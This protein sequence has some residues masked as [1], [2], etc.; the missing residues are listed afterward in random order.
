ML[1]EH[2]Q[3]SAVSG[4]CLMVVTA[5]NLVKGSQDISGLLKADSV[6]FIRKVGD[7]VILSDLMRSRQFAISYS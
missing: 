4:D 7:I 3:F 2:F 5:A 1:A 6:C